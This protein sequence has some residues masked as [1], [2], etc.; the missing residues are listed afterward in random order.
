MPSKSARRARS[1]SAATSSA[2]GASRSPPTTDEQ[3]LV[4]RGNAT[5]E[6]IVLLDNLEDVH[7]ALG[8]GIDTAHVQPTRHFRISADGGDPCYGDPG[9]PPGDTLEF[10]PLG[11]QFRILDRTFTTYSATET[12]AGVSFSNFE[13]L[14][15]TQPGT[16]AVQDYD[17]NHTNTA[18]AVATSPTQPGY[19]SVRIDTLHSDGLG[20]GWQESPQSFERNDGFYDGPQASL[21]MDGHS[22]GQMATFTA[23]VEAPGYYLISMLL[24]SPYTDV[25]G[26]RIRNEDTQQILRDDISTLAGESSNLS[27]VFYTDDGTLDITFINSLVNPTIF[28]VNSLSIRPAELITMGLD[29]CG[30]GTLLA[31]GVTI[32]SFNL[33]GAEPNS[34]VTVSATLG[35]IVNADTDAEI[36][37]TQIL[38]DA[39][40]EAT[41]DVRRAFGLGTSVITLEEVSGRGFGFATL[42]YFPPNERHFDLNHFNQFSMAVPSPTQT[43]VASPAKTNGFIGVLPSDIYSAGSGFGWEHEPGSFDNGDFVNDP[44]GDL[45]RDGAIDTESNSFYTE[46]P[47]DT[48]DVIVTMGTLNDLD[49]MRLRAN[50]DTV[51]YA[52]ETLAGEHLQTT[53]QVEVTDNIFLL[54]VG[55]AGLLPNWVINSVEIWSATQTEPIVFTVGPGSVMADEMTVS[56]VTAVTTANAGDEVTVKTS[57][58][59]I[60]TPDV[61]P[62][63]A[64]VQLSVPVGGALAFDILAPAHSGTPELT[65]I[66]TD[67][68]H[69]GSIEDAAFLAWLI[70]EVRRFDFNHVNN[71][72]SVGESPTADGAIGVTRLQLSPETEGYGWVTPPNSY[73]SIAPHIYD[74]APINY[75]AVTDFAIHQD[76]VTGHLATGGRIFQVEVKPGVKYDVR[77]FVGSLFKDQSVRFAVEGGGS[78]QSVATTAGVYSSMTFFDVM[79]TTGDGLLDVTFGAGGDLSPLWM[80]NGIDIAESSVGLP[81]A[82]PL[83]AAQS[84]LAPTASLTTADLQTAVALATAAWLRTGLTDVEAERLAAVTVQIAD[85]GGALGLAG[86]RSILIDDDAAGFGWSLDNDISAD[87]YDLLTVVAHELGHILGRPDL[88]PALHPGDLMSGQLSPGTRHASPGNADSFFAESLIDLDAV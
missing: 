4:T 50:G 65:A 52:G 38:T 80:A 11:N 83:P 20:Y 82:A 49:G 19:T 16:G 36:R 71:G 23:D 85:L 59:T 72:S 76:F 28:G 41:I 2:E 7:L 47:N 32:D 60:L 39:S 67:G 54:E 53:F 79:D 68:H 45:N 13:T 37:G 61:N 86:S 66:S 18:S 74:N 25:D 8:D 62:E 69:Q 10:Q 34:Y 35:A 30:T 81:P 9:T 5:D 84:A 70:P 63:I 29:T 24:G 26:V 14:P 55:D 73:D 3:E 15:V 42:D 40:G 22:F 78:S 27:V 1:Q 87:Q 88:D 51:L 46:L 31:D 17:F 57:L 43:P 6:P 48:Y 33:Y 58:G 12:F 44:R 75:T 56:T 77:G 21:I 64:G